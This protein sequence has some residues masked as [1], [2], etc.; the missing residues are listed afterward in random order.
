MNPQEDDVGLNK[1]LRPSCKNFFRMSSEFSE[2]LIS[3][4]GPAIK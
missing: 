4:D 2:N 3:P 1:E